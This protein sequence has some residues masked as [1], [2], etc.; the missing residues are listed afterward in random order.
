MTERAL[1][2]R[3][4][5]QPT[6]ILTQLQTGQLLV[7]NGDRGNAIIICHRHHAEIAGPG[8]AVGGSF[9]DIDCRR[10]IPIGKVSLVYPESYSQRQ[11]AWL[12]RQRWN[13]FTQ[14]IMK[15]HVPLDRANHLLMM[16]Y[17][18]FDR[19]LIEQLPDEIIA[20]LIG[21]LPKTIRIMRQSETSQ[22]QQA[23]Q[24]SELVVAI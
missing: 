3:P 1:I 14:H 9:V 2:R 12:I 13:L 16:L 5:V 7:V 15:N 18:Y 17:K 8:A 21:V 23:L 4:I 10:V 24:N 22:Q 20:Q 6:E 19:Q 11:K